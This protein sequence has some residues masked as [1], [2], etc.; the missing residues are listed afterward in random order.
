[1]RYEP[2]LD[3]T[4]KGVVEGIFQPT[5]SAVPDR[6]QLM[7]KRKMGKNL[8]KL[9][10]LVNLLFTIVCMYHVT[11]TLYST[12]NPLNPEIKVYEKALNEV[13]FPIVFKICGKEH[14]NGSMRFINFGYAT[15]YNFYGGISKLTSPVPNPQVPK[16]L[17]P[18]TKG[19]GVSL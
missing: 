3:N 9:V 6:Q 19:T 15:E 5:D 10:Y 8:S 16:S 13:S 17:N 7:Q 12:I 4:L 18:K 2:E 14:S 1:M 11:N